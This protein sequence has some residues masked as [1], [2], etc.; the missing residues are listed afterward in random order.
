VALLSRPPLGFR[1][2]DPK[3]PYYGAGFLHNNFQGR[4]QKLFGSIIFG[5]NPS[6][7]VSFYEPL[8]DPVHRLSFST[9][10]SFSR[11]RNKSAIE[12]EATGDFEELHYDFGVGLG[13]RLSLFE[14]VQLSLSYQV[15][16]ASS[17][18]PGRTVSDGGIDRFFYTTASYSFA[19]ST[20]I[21]LPRTV[22]GASI[23]KYGLALG[24]KLF[25]FGMT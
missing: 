6:A 13:K 18:R 8:I 23:T 12:A 24:R 4:N 10:A 11:V 9:A 19:R 1:D 17:Y 25:R 3:K 21:R 22:L 14:S 15:M 16:E 7:Q 5:H 20:R 2:G